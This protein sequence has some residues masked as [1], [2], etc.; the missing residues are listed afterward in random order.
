MHLLP[1]PALHPELALDDQ[2]GQPRTQAPAADVRAGESEPAVRLDHQL[3][4]RRDD[5]VARNHPGAGP[6][7]SAR[8]EPGVHQF[9]P[10]VLDGHAFQAEI[11]PVEQVD[12]GP[13]PGARPGRGRGEADRPGP[14]LQHQIPEDQQLAAAGVEPALARVL[15]R[16]E[17]HGGA[18]G[19]RQRDPGRHHH[20]PID[21]NLPGPGG[22][23][24]DVAGQ[25]LAHQDID[26]HAI[27]LSADIVHHNA[28]RQI[29]PQAGMGA[30][31]RV[32]VRRK[33][34]V[35]DSVEGI[36]GIP[37]VALVRRRVRPIPRPEIQVVPSPHRVGYFAGKTQVPEQSV[38]ADQIHLFV[39]LLVIVG[40]LVHVPDQQAPGRDIAIVVTSPWLAVLQEEILV[41]AQ[42]YL[43]DLAP[44]VDVLDDH[45]PQAPGYLHQV[46]VAHP[47]PS[48][49]GQGPGA[50]RVG[51]VF[52]TPAQGP[53]PHQAPLAD[54]GAV[55][56]RVQLAARAQ[57]TLV[58]EVR[59]AEHV[60]E[61]VAHGPGRDREHVTPLGR[62]AEPGELAADADAPPVGRRIVAQIIRVQPQRGQAGGRA[63]EEPRGHGEQVDEDNVHVPVVIPRIGHSVR[64]VVV[65]KSHVHI[66]VGLLQD[67]E[68]ELIE[69]ADR[70]RSF[71]HVRGRRLPGAVPPWQHLTL[72]LQLAP[73]HLVVEVGE[74]ARPGRIEQIL[75]PRGCLIDPGRLVLE[76][77]EDDQGAQATRGLDRDFAGRPGP[78]RI[79]GAEKLAPGRTD[80]PQCKQGQE[81]IEGKVERKKSGKEL[82]VS[83]HPWHSSPASG[84]YPTR[85]RVLVKSRGW[86]PFF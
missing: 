10:G 15:T 65:E 52:D 28:Q 54:A 45:I 81:N 31:S 26:D 37:L 24:A 18:S 29:P 40:A 36:G 38:R 68:I 46:L 82:A 51:P 27:P 70:A 53:Q 21:E 75:G 73:G 84:S 12:A 39:A 23:R 59:Q 63:D 20:I 78:H 69:A 60:P 4:A 33:A 56:L 79:A 8:R 5:Q 17:Q 41:R 71:R 48:Q 72:D 74:T 34:R 67:L 30:G 19:N 77:G 50:E 42:R 44:A 55:L 13:V 58:K 35:P 2:L 66:L 85:L 14:A 62:A 47:D 9:M 86:K 57:R 6:A 3:R 16:G 43:V 64:P 22:V 83:A 80:T 25:G 32:G 1:G 7:G 11:L 76:L 49:L 61:F